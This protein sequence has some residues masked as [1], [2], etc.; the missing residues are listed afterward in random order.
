MKE[1]DLI[2]LGSGPGGYEAAIRAAQLGF[3][4]AVIEK[5]KTLGGTCLNIGCIPSKSLLESSELFYQAGHQFDLHGISHEKLKIDVRKMFQRKN[6]VVKAT[7]DGLDFLMKKNKVDVYYGYGRFESSDTLVIDEKEKIKSVRIIVATGSEV[8]SLPHIPIDEKRILS[9]TGALDLG[10]VPKRLIVIGG[11]VIGV[12]LGS[13]FAR[14]GSKT[15]VI[16]VMPGLI[17][18]MDRELGRGLEKALR[19]IQFEYAFESKVTS[20]RYKNEKI[21]E[22]TY[23][24]SSGEKTSIEADY[25]LSSIGRRP[26]TQGLGLE[27]IGVKL[28]EKGR[29]EVDE[30]FKTNIEGVYA[31]GDVIKGAML[32]HKASEEG[33]VCVE[34]MRGKKSK[35]NYAIIP[36]V[37][38]T[39]P[40]VASVGRSE[41]DLKRE[42]F[43]YKVGKF[44]FKAS[45]RARVSGDLDG[46]VK[47]LAD[48]KTD[49]VLG[50]HM[51]GPRCADMIAEAALAMEYRASSEDIGMMIH[52]HPTFSEA[53]KEAS[54]DVR[55]ESINQ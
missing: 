55:G 53:I 18:T 15:T 10:V 31:I 11:G 12:E 1:Y 47:V 27:R 45:A 39:W 4:T 26:F 21:L 32:A 5:R 48:E 24:N 8:L 16:D 46:F 36:S 30:D 3:K 6:D 13:V 50:A 51:I 7:T 54:L 20:V 35:V 52:P 28:D 38:Y 41:E 29:I 25:V 23:E 19:K 14:L 44:P 37:V 17:A 33:I 34:R 9:S 22:I 49:E 40:E 43:A 2:V 42:G